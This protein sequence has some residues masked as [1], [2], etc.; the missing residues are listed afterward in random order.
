MH[1]YS[2]ALIAVALI[3]PIY[4]LIDPEQVEKNQ[5]DTVDGQRYNGMDFW[6]T[7]YTLY[8]KY[9]RPYQFLMILLLV[10]S[11]ILY[12][13]IRYKLKVKIIKQHKILCIIQIMVFIYQGV[14][15]TLLHKSLIIPFYAQMVLNLYCRTMIIVKTDRLLKWMHEVVTRP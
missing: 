3:H 1:I 5:K 8:I 15:I 2:V 12:H 10:Y 4:M 11:Q 14:A 9:N 7:K 13:L 6:L